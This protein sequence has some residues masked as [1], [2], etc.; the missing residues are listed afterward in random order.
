MIIEDTELSGMDLQTNSLVSIGAID[1][2]NPKNQFYGECRVREGS[3]INQEGIDI[4]GITREQAQDPKKQT[5][6]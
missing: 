3:E 6:E 2:A 4:A 5:E 1:L